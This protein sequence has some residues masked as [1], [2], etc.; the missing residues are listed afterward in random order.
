MRGAGLARRQDA[1]LALGITVFAQL[2]LWLNIE[3]ATQYGSDLANALTTFVATSVLVLRRRAPLLT[4]CVV[5]AVIAVPDL[6]SPLTV[7]LWG[8]FVPLLIA[9]YSVARYR[10][11]RVAFAGLMVAAVTLLVVELRVPVAGTASNIPFIWV[12]FGVVAA[13]GRI[14]RARESERDETV[15]TAVLEERARIA[16]EL[17]DIVGHSVSVMVVQA[18]AA[19]DL[20]DRDP[21]RARGPL[22]SVQET[23]GQAI[24]E[25]RRMLGLLRDES[26]APTLTPQPGTAQLGELVEQMSTVGLPVDLR[27]EGTP[28]PLA[29][30]IELAAY[31]VVQEALTNTLKHA[32]PATSTVVLRYGDDALDLEVID[33][34][35]S[36]RS[37]GFGHGLIGMRER[38]T[39]YDGRIESGP[40]PEGG[41]AV[42]VHLPVSQLPPR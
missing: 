27:I 21:Q 41:F 1:L 5:A 30:G 14:L 40:L 12:P 20:L 36:T 37:N 39:L 8:D 42:R 32:G 22:R 18:G 15:R 7:Q 38:V 13:A 35:D 31:R 11:T 34:G 33:D 9:A 29:P 16:R 2:D 6:I 17:H 23:G 3:Q 10:P 26:S 4:V 25:L 28:R 24:G 19:E